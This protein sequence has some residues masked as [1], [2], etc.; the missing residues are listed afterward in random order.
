[1]RRLF[2]IGVS[3]AIA[4]CGDIP[5]P[6][7]HQG[8]GDDLAKPVFDEFDELV[9]EIAPHRL[10]AQLGSFDGIPGDGA[11]SLRRALKGALERRGLLVVSEE[12]DM[13]VTPQLHLTSG[14]ANESKLEIT[15]LITSKEGTSL[16]QAKQQG[17]APSQVLN[18]TWGA[19]A[20]DIA[21]GGA[22]GIVT[23]VQSTFTKGRGG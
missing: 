7:R 21:E 1:L 19:L 10:T 4:A 14:Q 6:F 9:P 13:L 8:R 20:H 12:G 17:L 3:L 18:G 2:F 5:Q 11:Q 15:W 23:V 16:G 22:D